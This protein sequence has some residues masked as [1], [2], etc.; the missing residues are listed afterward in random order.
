MQLLYYN[1]IIS[2]YFNHTIPSWAGDRKVLK[3]SLILLLS[4]YI[5]STIVE[6]QPILKKFQMYKVIFTQRVS[7]KRA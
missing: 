6:I 5:P 3:I 4:L 1:Y 7:K 2:I